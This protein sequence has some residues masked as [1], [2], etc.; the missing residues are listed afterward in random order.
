MINKSFK[1]HM[2]INYDNKCQTCKYFEY[3]KVCYFCNNPDQPDETL[4]KY[5][6]YSSGCSLH[7]K[8]ISQSVMNK[9]K[10][11]K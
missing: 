7:T 6:Y 4:K 11:K 5:T 9:I 2:F 3:N 1:K 10:I 8:G